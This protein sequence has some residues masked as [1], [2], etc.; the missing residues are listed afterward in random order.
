MTP[1]DAPTTL[2]QKL[3]AFDAGADCAYTWL[4]R[5]LSDPDTADRIV[6]LARRRHV[7]GHA[8]YGD[9]RLYEYSRGRLLDEIDEEIADSVV[10]ALR[11]LSL[12]DD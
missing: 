5:Y 10:Y 7:A 11:R 12:K 3:A 9:G 6:R 1:P 2:G 4:T 8:R